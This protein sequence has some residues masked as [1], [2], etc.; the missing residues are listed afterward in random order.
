MA[1]L[2]VRGGHIIHRIE[3]M[4]DSSCQR[5]EITTLLRLTD[6]PSS[7]G[8][9][10]NLNDRRDNDHRSPYCGCFFSI[11]LDWKETHEF[12]FL[13][14]CSFAFFWRPT[15]S[16]WLNECDLIT[17]TRFF[18]GDQEYYIIRL[19]PSPIHPEKVSA[20]CGCCPSSSSNG[21]VRRKRKNT[22]IYTLSARCCVDHR[23]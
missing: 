2:V 19:S 4:I 13:V 3:I 20:P 11:Y 17:G 6:Q 9:Y 22:I 1:H 21:V 12:L 15:N 7:S 14:L 23:G 10:S 8:V 16:F 5:G 18:F